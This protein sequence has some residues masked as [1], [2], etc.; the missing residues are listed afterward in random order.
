MKKVLKELALLPH[1]EVIM[2]AYIVEN[3]WVNSCEGYYSLA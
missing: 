3:L 1:E 2:K